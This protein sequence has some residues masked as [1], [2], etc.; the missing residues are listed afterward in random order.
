MS[1]LDRILLFL[2]A[3]CL[4][5]ELLAA[6]EEGSTPT[7]A[8]PATA[9]RQSADP[10]YAAVI[11]DLA[12]KPVALSEFKGKPLLINFWA[13]WCG[14]CRK[15]I[16]DLIDLSAKYQPKGVVVL[17]IAVDNPEKAREF[18]KTKGIPYQVL[19]G[20]DQAID[21]IKKTAD[22][23]ALIPFTLAIGPDGNIVAVKRGVMDRG[24]LDELMQSLVPAPL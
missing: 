13:T 19:V 20:P 17:G 16:P 21:I 12:G 22:A 7:P 9:V 14:P 11:N 6:G 24:E 10:V 18:V 3:C 5:L 23:K 1:K 8:A 4:P 15:E 2:L